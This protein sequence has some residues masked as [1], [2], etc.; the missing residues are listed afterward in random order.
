MTFDNYPSI[1]TLIPQKMKKILSFIVF[2][3]L[4]A[5]IGNAANS[6][7]AIT[8]RDTAFKYGNGLVNAYSLSHYSGSS[9]TGI[10]ELT[11]T[12]LLGT[13]KNPGK[14]FFTGAQLISLLKG[15]KVEIHQVINE[16]VIT[17]F[18]LPIKS[19]SSYRKSSYQAEGSI[20]KPLGTSLSFNPI[21]S[22]WSL[23]IFALLSLA[24]V[25]VIGLLTIKISDPSKNTKLSRLIVYYLLNFAIFIS[26][27]I[28]NL[29]R[30]FLMP[31]GEII[32]LMLSIAGMI[33][34]LLLSTSLNQHNS[35]VVWCA[36]ILGGA[37]PFMSL[38]LASSNYFWLYLALLAGCSVIS[39]GLRELRLFLD[40]LDEAMR[41]SKYIEM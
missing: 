40:S 31:D 18:S 32:I 2:L 16:R 1:F 29:D 4:I 26:V 11:I 5:F 17:N 37:G 33:I 20:I 6:K 39:I 10:V 38:V 3:V 25:L 36:C 8:K 21:K 14:V 35:W 12:R 30:F 27:K 19:T 15:E 7:L 24:S 13:L 22:D 41:N 23:T 28:F 34:S 9:D